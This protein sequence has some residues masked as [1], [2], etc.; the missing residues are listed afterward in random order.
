MLA[1]LKHTVTSYRSFFV[2]ST[3]KSPI[4]LQKLHSILII[5]TKKFEILT[6][7]RLTAMEKFSIHVGDKV[8]LHIGQRFGVFMTFSL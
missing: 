1:V 4:N 3:R 7:K 2:H 6:E 8:P 5:A